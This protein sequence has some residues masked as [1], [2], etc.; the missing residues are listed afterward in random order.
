MEKSKWN[1]SL[2]V[3]EE[4]WLMDF[5]KRKEGFPGTFL[6]KIQPMTKAGSS[7]KDL[8]SNDGSCGNTV[9][10]S[11]LSLSHWRLTCIAV[12][13]DGSRFKA[14]ATATKRLHER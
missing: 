4:Q 5:N 11:R 3:L 8:A 1:V 10:K 14:S 2:Q 13:P 6:V 7:W 9:L 12:H